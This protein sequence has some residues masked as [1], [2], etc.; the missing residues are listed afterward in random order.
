MADELRLVLSE[1]FRMIPVDLSC[2]SCREKLKDLNSPSG[3][4][5]CRFQCQVDYSIL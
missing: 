1:D 2:G 5:D 3:S 4:L